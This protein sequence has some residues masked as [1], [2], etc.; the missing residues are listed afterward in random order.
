MIEL[1]LFFKKDK[2]AMGLLG[3]TLSW[4]FRYLANLGGT[5]FLENIAPSN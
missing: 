4:F 1:F 2:P 3:T 5:L